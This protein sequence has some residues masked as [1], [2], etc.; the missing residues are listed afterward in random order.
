MALEIYRT[1]TDNAYVCFCCLFI[2]AQSPFIQMSNNYDVEN[3]DFTSQSDV[4][5][6]QNFSQ[7]S[8]KIARKY[9]EIMLNIVT[10]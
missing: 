4:G 6:D 8:F 9:Y 2:S 5:S 1:S 7:K 3:L 10:I